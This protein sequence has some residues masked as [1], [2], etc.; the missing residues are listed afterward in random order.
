MENQGHIWDMHAWET[1]PNLPR[2]FVL[3]KQFPV[4]LLGLSATL[5]GS[6]LWA[7]NPRVQPSLSLITMGLCLLS[8]ATA[9]RGSSGA[10][11]V[12]LKEVH[13]I[14]FD[15]FLDKAVQQNTI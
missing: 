1:T 15:G 13:L 2:L 3:L 9:V 12:N 8:T 6:L 5:P 10:Q 11:L 7:A 4:G 14:S